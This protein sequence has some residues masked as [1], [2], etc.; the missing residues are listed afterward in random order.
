MSGKKRRKTAPS[1]TPWDKLGEEDL[2]PA[3]ALVRA[4]HKSVYT[5]RHESYA[6]DIDFFNQFTRDCCPWCGSDLI[7]KR[8]HEKSGLQRYQ[9]GNCKKS[10]SPVTGTIFEDRKLPLPAWVDFFLQLFSFESINA[11]TREDRRSDTT[12]PYWLGKVF[13]VLEGIQDGM[14]L[15]GRVQID[16]TYYPVPGKEAVVVDGKL[17]RG[18]SKNKICIAIGCDNSGHSCFARAGFGKPSAGRILEAYAAHIECGSLLVHDMEKAHR[19]LV[20]ELEL[21]E[22]VY[23]SKLIS[24]LD[25]ADNPLGDVN[26]LC[27][28]LK[29]FLNSHS[30]FDRNDLDGW[31]NLFS[32]M[33][34]PP[35]NKM[36]K[37]VFMLNRAMGNP[38]TLRF[39]DFYNIKPSSGG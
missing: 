8:G 28:L 37:A 36:E 34:N 19:K 22:E 26:R 21:K 6:G 4:T 27:Y 25:D 23:N 1:S 38:K 11:M 10:F 39:R 2:T 24:K 9:C 5:F 31:L 29:R 18:L 32:V 3:Q 14:V 33:M 16:E 12:I 15:S 7:S 13:S 35:A 17:L 30:G 20:E